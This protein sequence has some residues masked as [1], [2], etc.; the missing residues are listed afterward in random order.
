VH[1]YLPVVAAFAVPSAIAAL[2][3]VTTCRRGR[4]VQLPTV[5]ALVVTQ[6]G[7]FAVQEIVERLA[8]HVSL[9]DLVSQP[10]VRLGLALQ[11][12]TATAYLFAVRLLRRT[13]GALLCLVGR[14]DF[15]LALP[16]A[17]VAI[18]EARRITIGIVWR[19][20]ARAP[21]VVAA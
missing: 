4:A 5:R 18:V 9:S 21:P 8:S 13:I 10:A 6:L 11:V 16:C 12:L 20:P 19:A 15:W 2:L 3:W 1:A 17:P 7:L 14:A